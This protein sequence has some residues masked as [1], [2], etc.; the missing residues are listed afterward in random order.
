M[1]YGKTPTN[2][3]RQ[4][5][6]MNY[7]KDLMFFAICQ[8]YNGRNIT[9]IFSWQSFY[10]SNTSGRR[11]FLLCKSVQGDDQRLCINIK[12][13]HLL[14]RIAKNIR[15]YKVYVS[16]RSAAGARMMIKDH[17]PTWKERILF[18]EK[19]YKYTPCMAIV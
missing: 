4:R 12:S 14:Q 7:H 11:V 17:R 18:T 16:Q 2:I 19:C 8:G 6:E 5:Y 1:F 3:G 10:V 13:K 15:V 9:L